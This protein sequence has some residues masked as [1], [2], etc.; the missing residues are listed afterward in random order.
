MGQCISISAT[1]EGSIPLNRSPSTLASNVASST[2]V[3]IAEVTTFHSSGEFILTLNVK[4]YDY[5]YPLL[6]LNIAVAHSGIQSDL[7]T[8][9]DPN[10]IFHE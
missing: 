1:C 2:R 5:R 4:I 6:T 10:D 9:A 3:E 8:A 7:E